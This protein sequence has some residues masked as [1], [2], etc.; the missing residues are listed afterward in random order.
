MT[1]TATWGYRVIS[2]G[3]P[4]SALEYLTSHGVTRDD[5]LSAVRKVVSGAYNTSASTPVVEATQVTYWVTNIGRH[6]VA[7]QPVVYEQGLDGLA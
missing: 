6:V 3:S 7:I 2:D 4:A 1:T 5:A